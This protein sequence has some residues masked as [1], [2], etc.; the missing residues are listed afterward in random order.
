MNGYDRVTAMHTWAAQQPYRTRHLL[1]K[2][3]GF[4]LKDDGFDDFIPSDDCPYHI[5]KHV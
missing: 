3:D 1:Y 4:M 2:D 5:M